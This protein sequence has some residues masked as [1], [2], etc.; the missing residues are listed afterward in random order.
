MGALVE[1]VCPIIPLLAVC[2]NVYYH[3][4]VS[5]TR[6]KFVWKDH[7]RCMSKY[8]NLLRNIFTE[9][10]S[11]EMKLTSNCR[12]KML[13]NSC[14][15]SSRLN[16]VEVYLSVQVTP[17]RS[18][19]LYLCAFKFY[20]WHIEGVFRDFVAAKY[21]ESQSIQSWFRFVRKCRGS[22]RV[23]M[24]G[25]LLYTLIYQLPVVLNVTDTSRSLRQL[26]QWQERWWKWKK[27]R[28]TCRTF[29]TSLYYKMIVINTHP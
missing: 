3:S 20:K 13:R 27:I 21:F 24:I 16:D 15:Q 17:L 28:D 26:Q 23:D 10:A 2:R 4:T 11:G 12:S 7:N 22:A 6:M 25:P 9:K 5:R 8:W 29:P 1:G 14:D 19:C 18:S